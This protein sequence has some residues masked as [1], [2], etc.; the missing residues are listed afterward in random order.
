MLK[1]LRIGKAVA[2]LVALLVVA[3][4]VV[5]CGSDSGD[6]SGGSTNSTSSGGGSGSKSLQGNGKELA[7][8]TMTASNVYGANQ[9]AGAKKM[10]KQLGFK[11]K[12][13]QNNFSQ[14][15]QDQQ[16]QQYVASGAK[17]AASIIF[18][19]VADAAVNS[20]RQLSRLGPV[21]NITQEPNEKQ[22]PY[23][24][25]YAGANQQLIGQ[26]AAEM[27]LK[28]REQAKKNGMK[29][30]NPKGNL[31]VFQHPEGEKTGVERWKGFTRATASAPFNVIGTTYGAN[32]PETGYQIGSQVVPKIKGKVDFLYVSNQQAA[33]GIIRALKENGIKPGKDVMIVSSDCSGSLEAVENGET[34][35]TG[36]QS[37]A[38]EGLLGVVTAAQYIAAG[39]T[40][41][42]VQQYKVSPTQPKFGM[43][44]PAKLNYMPHAAAIGKEGINKTKIWGYSAQQICAG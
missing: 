40:Q 20:I 10:A 43:K 4:V 13:Y 27:L 18:P 14:P 28:A 21:I 34:F 3:G 11:L 16:V 17:P 38:I 9:I 36:L 24:K 26:V 19:W 15:Q 8:F 25:A 31:Y 29:F 32:S 5:G 1:N 41:G 37:G 6:N 2:L 44:P 35:G 39:K 42:N 23:V 33:N 30:H 7:L 22:A 12:V